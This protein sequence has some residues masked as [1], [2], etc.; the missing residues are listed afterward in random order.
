MSFA[1][2]HLHTEYSMLDGAARIDDVVRIAAAD[3]QPGVGITDHGVLYGVVD[4][5]KASRGQGI[6][7]V[8]G[9]EAYFTDGSRFDRPTGAANQRYHL[10]LFA[11]NDTG[12]RNLMKLSSR[13]FLEG[14]YYKPRI[15]FDLLAEHS[16]GIIATSGCL[17]GLVPQLLGP[18]QG[19]EE[20]SKARPRDFDAALAAAG[21]F[22]DIFGRDNFLIEVQ[23]HGIQAQRKI[24]GDLL[25]ISRRL[26]APLL[27]TNDAHYSRPG[28]AEAHDV[29][30]CIQTGSLQTDDNRLKFAGGNDYYVKSAAEMRSLFPAEDFPG[31]CDN[32]LW[33]VERANVDLEFGKILLPHFPVPPGHTEVSYLEE[34]V[35]TGARQRYGDPLG[36]EVRERIQHELKIIDEMGFPAYF[37]IV[38]DLM[39]FA[40][41]RGIRTGPG[42][43]SAAGSIVSYCLGITSLDP[44]RY[45]L[46]F[47]RFLNPGRR[48]MPDIDM[49]FDERHRADVIRYA[50]EKYGSDH[51]AQIV[52]F[53]T[54]KGK[55]AIRDAARVLGHPYGL[56]DKVAKAMP[57]AI[58]GKEATLSHVLEPPGEG[59]DAVER[60]WYANAQELRNLYQSDPSVRQVVDA[61]RDLEGLRRQD[62]IHAAAVVI[63][64][65]PLTDLIPIQQK[66]EDSEVVT[67]YEMGAVESLGL[68]KMDFLGLRN[69]SII[70]RTLELI[71]ETTGR[72]L[73]ID[74]VPLDDG[75]TFELLQRGDTIGVFQL[76]GAPM[77]ALI[78]SLRPDRFEDVIALVALYRPGP[79]GANMH[80]LYA[81]RKNGR[82]AVEPLHPAITPFLE[83][84]YQIMVYQEQ[85][86]QVA[87]EMAGYSM[88]EADNLRKAMGKKIKSVMD[89][90]K[91]KF[92]AGCVATGYTERVGA[93]LFDLIAHFAG[94]GFNRCLTGDTEIVDAATGRRLT[95]KELFE[96]D[97]LPEVSTLDGWVRSRRRPR[98]VWQNGVKPVYR[99][100]TRSGRSITA[101]DNHPFLT[102]A[103]WR[104]LDELGA[105]D[106]IAQSS[107]L[108]WTPS[109]RMAE[110]ELATLGYVLAEGNTCHRSGLYLYTRD[111]A[112]LEDMVRRL[113]AFPNSKATID[114]SKSATS[115][116]A[117]RVDP[118]RQNGAV[119]FIERCGLRQC[120]ATE[121]HMPDE[122]FGLGRSDLARLLGAVWSGDGCCD[123][124]ASV[125]RT[126]HYATSSERLARDLAHLL[127]RLGIR[128]TLS[129]KTCRHRDG[130]KRGW[131]IHVVTE[132]AQRRFAA[133]IGPYL[134]GRR[135]SD[136]D[137]LLTAIPEP[138]GFSST[139]DQVAA[140]EVLP[141]IRSE[142]RRAAGEAGLT[143]AELCRRGGLSA[144]LVHGGEPGNKGFRR[145][146]LHLMAKAFDSELLADLADADVWWDR[147]VSIEPAGEEMTYDLEVPGTHNFVANDFVVHNSHSAAYGLVAYQTAYLK[148]HYPAE[149]LAAL[150]TATKKDKDRT[151]V[152]LNDCRQA[153]IEVLVPD[154]N[155]SDMDFTV[156]D[157]RI[158]FG[159]SAI[160]NVGEGVVEHILQARRDGPFQDFA[161]FIERVDPIALNKRTVE[162]LVK[163]GA[164]DGLGHPRKGLFLVYESMLDATLERRRNE[165]MGQFSL[166]ADNADVSGEGSVEVPATEWRQKVKL[167][168]EKEMLGLYISD[169]PLL[170]ARTTLAAVAPTS[171]A[172]L[173]DMAD[174]SQVSLGGLVGSITRRWTKNGDPMI[175][176]LL[177]TLE[178][179]V[180][181]L[182]FP[183][184]VQEVG[185]LIVE[186]S[187]VVVSGRLDHRGDDVKLVAGEVRE[188]EIR[189][190]Q[191]V[192]LSVPAGRLSA[193]VVGRLKQILSN[194]PGPAQV[195]LQLTGGDGPKVLRLSDDHRVEPRSALFAEIKELLG[196]KAVL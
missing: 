50:A 45:D 116:H 194:H 44:I 149:S 182:C 147:I 37:L 41:E 139:V 124:S 184:T 106:L 88:A 49:D 169:H 164:F 99:I 98:H 154:V 150:L 166:F 9:I 108:E 131:Q 4:F 26:D 53:S 28:D 22:Q 127:L 3:G 52:T 64:P 21:R 97:H 51:V 155:E 110:H 69:L 151:A 33:V 105:A 10:L 175:F 173:A 5:V 102:A 130:T 56:G 43:G 31:A 40:H 115:V 11:E 38:W 95:M 156:R 14:Y 191:L 59:S 96:E 133:L 20:N 24:M 144:R 158:R 138:N 187:V 188:L 13:A 60:D 91:A 81:D 16:E 35:Y 132:E 140:T 85:V 27:A 55:Q 103:G 23:D 165:D 179:S 62:S 135:A 80:N 193:E 180:E 6:T 137:D 129:S 183:R 174:R 83:D 162:S 120:R 25:D 192:R 121:K 134:V 66:G 32:T 34:L 181:V 71:E 86:M 112:V 107:G 30:L 157:G 122:V 82:K 92:V 119:E 87:Q 114:R 141:L 159:L 1:H 168:F 172:D 75:A 8:I 176:F 2:L 72:R 178:G 142:A 109:T 128:T 15:D 146:T 171:I 48:E 76:E 93:D 136:L 61:A 101:T 39:R 65:Q 90:E 189:D 58:L 167:G 125:R 78:R 143:I 67:Q 73:D 163:A 42:R 12:Y 70:E 7:P 68:L 54:I 190:D 126:L 196:P 148:A 89:A 153:G 186:D 195:L 185:H 74:N 117:A 177:E 57:P 46:I 84:T 19:V 63:S 161:D 36:E 145:D 152:Y 113:E 104:R 17:G 29:L 123:V 77:R 18:D 100:T 94:Y 47:E 160:R 118:G 111:E 170:G 79:M